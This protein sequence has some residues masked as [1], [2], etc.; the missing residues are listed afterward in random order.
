MHISETQYGQAIPGKDHG[1]LRIGHKI[2][3]VCRDWRS[4]KMEDNPKVVVA[5]KFQPVNWR[6]S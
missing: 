4:Y 5:C 3:W 2:R 1:I 6:L